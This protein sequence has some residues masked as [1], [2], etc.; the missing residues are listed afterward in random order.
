MAVDIVVYSL[1]DKQQEQIFWQF[2][3][4]KMS[5]QENDI[6]SM[7]VNVVGGRSF[8]IYALRNNAMRV[9]MYVKC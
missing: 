5:I 6:F 7:N 8:A 2:V 4:S 1:D 3:S 9:G